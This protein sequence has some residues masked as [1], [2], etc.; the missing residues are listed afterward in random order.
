MARRIHQVLN[1]VISFRRRQLPGIKVF[2]VGPDVIIP[3]NSG[4]GGHIDGIAPQI[5]VHDFC[6]SVWKIAIGV[7]EFVSPSIPPQLHDAQVLPL[8]EGGEASVRPRCYAKDLIKA[9]VDHVHFAGG[10]VHHLDDAPW[11]GTAQPHP[12]A[13][14]GQIGQIGIDQAFGNGHGR[15]SIFKRVIDQHTTAGGRVNPALMKVKGLGADG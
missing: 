11:W 5:E 3:E 8:P 10:Q 1:N 15:E 2:Q 13:V 6:Y 4:V 14:N 7:S 9:E 12:V